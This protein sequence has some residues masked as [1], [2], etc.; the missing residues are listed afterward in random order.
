[1]RTLGHVVSVVV[2]IGLVAC[3]TTQG[4]GVAI[5]APAA[6]LPRAAS[7]V[8]HT[9]VLAGGCFWGVQSVFEHVRGVT[10]V[11][12]GYAGG[13]ASTARYEVVET[14]RTGHAESVQVIYD[15]SSVTYG[16][17]LRVFFG[18]AHDPTQ[19]NRQGP[20]M[21]TQYRSVI[22]FSDDDE[23]RVA[24]AYVNQLTQAHAFR[25]PIVTEI[26]A[27]AAFYPAETYHQDY[28]E[29][30]PDDLYIRIND[31]PKLVALKRVFPDLF[32]EPVRSR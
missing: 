32:G 24:R 17:L 18:V 31:A 3:V 15:A 2:A 22:F 23:A 9:A 30:H 21:G 27:L 1:M 25:Q 7:P 6:D 29:Q 28:A 26:V 10:K 20:D 5:P 8:T 11:V 13:A 12:A 14:G 16:Q 4:Q 19:L